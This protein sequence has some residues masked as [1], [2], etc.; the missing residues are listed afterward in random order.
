MPNN[1]ETPHGSGRASGWRW[2][3]ALPFIALFWVPFY[4][5]IDPA[6]GGVPFFYWYQFAWVVITAVLTIFVFHQERE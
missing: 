3:F 4:N 1:V 2:L 5:R 6:I